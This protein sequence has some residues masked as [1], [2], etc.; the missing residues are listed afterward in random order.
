[1][2]SPERSVDSLSALE[3]AAQDASQKACASLEDG[4][5]VGAL[6]NSGGAY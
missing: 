2:D 6:H 4:A 5:Q 1:M 3:G